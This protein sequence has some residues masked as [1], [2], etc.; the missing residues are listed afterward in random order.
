MT[1]LDPLALDDLELAPRPHAIFPSM[2]SAHVVI[3]IRADDPYSSCSARGLNV[4]SMMTARVLRQK[5]ADCDIWHCPD[6]REVMLKLRR[7]EPRQRR[8][9][10]HVVINTPGF[11][12]PDAFGE[13]ATTWPNVQFVMLNHTGL[14]YLS[15]DPD[16]W[17]NIRALLDMQAML[18]N[19]HVAG[20]N[21]RFCASIKAG[22]GKRTLLLPNLFDLEQFKPLRPKRRSYAPLRIG[23]FAEGRPWKNQLAAAQGALSIARALGVPL[24]LYVNDEHPHDNWDRVGLIRARRELFRGLPWATL[25]PVTWQPWHAFLHT[26]EAMD[27]ML[28]PSFDESFGMVPADGIAM[29]VPCV[30]APS[31]EW[32]PRSWQALEPFDPASIARTGLRLLRHRRCALWSGRRALKRYV[33]AGAR[34]WL[35]FLGSGRRLS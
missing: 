9:I 32:T 6:A 20:N 22:F 3:V 25:V 16:G 21:P 29:G 8:P 7:E 11:V 10:T 12:P 26:V 23:S 5:G 27:L 14:A 1:D 15:I 30:T 17:Q 31:L 24:E 4:T 35:R 19:V 34:T 28:Y 33:H 2:E 13:L 18:D